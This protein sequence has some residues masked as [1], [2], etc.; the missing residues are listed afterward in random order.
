[1]QKK[2]EKWLKRWHMVTHLRALSESYPMNTNTTGIRWFS[3]ILCPCALDNSSLNISSIDCFCLLFRSSRQPR[4]RRRLSLRAAHRRR[5]RRR[6]RTTGQRGR[7]SGRAPPPL[8]GMLSRPCSGRRV[9]RN[10][11][12]V[13][14]R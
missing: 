3:K 7:A 9:R 11:S 12:H 6:R 10:T 1:M 13:C 14:Y 2:P 5:R 8:A 4:R